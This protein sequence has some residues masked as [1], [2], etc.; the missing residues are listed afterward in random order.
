MLA[1]REESMVRYVVVEALEAVI[2]LALSHDAEAIKAI[3]PFTGQTIYI[4]VYNPD[5]SFYVTICD[6]AL[7]LFTEHEGP[8]VGRLRVPALVLARSVLGAAN[9][10]WMDNEE[11]V[12]DGDTATLSRLLGVAGNFRIPALVS[13]ILRE[14]LPDFEGIDDLF[15]AIRSQDADWMARLEHL[16]QL[17]N[18]MMHEIRAQAEIS[19]TLVE[20]VREIRKQWDTDRRTG[21][22]STIVGFCLIITAFLAHNGYL[23]LP[24]IYSLT[25]ETAVLLIIAMV[26]LIPKMI[27]RR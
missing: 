5:I 10:N 2:N 13:G 14:W 1:E 26:L 19:R 18:T 17:T 7:Q 27:R 3:R 4:R 8:V 21:Q 9:E 12:M 15:S 24:A 22:V 23:K 16:P 20:E 6:G 11:I 25:F